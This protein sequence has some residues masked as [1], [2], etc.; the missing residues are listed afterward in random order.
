MTSTRMITEPARGAHARPRRPAWQAVGARLGWGYGERLFQAARFVTEMEYQHLV[1]EE[2]ARKVQPMVNVFGEGGTGYH[3]EINADIS[4]EFA[5]AVYRFGHSMLTE[6]STRIKGRRHRRQR[7][8]CSTPSSTRRPSWPGYATP[9]AAAGAVVRGMTR[10]V[11]QRDRRVRHRGAAQQ[12]AR[13]AARPGHASTWPGPAT[14]ASRRSTRRGA[15]FYAESGNTQL[16][17]Y[18]SWAD[19]GFSLKHPESLVNFIAAYGTHPSI[20]GA[21]LLAARR[22]AAA[23]L[24]YGEA[25]PDGSPRRRPDHRRRGRGEP[26]T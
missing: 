14:P 21:D 6:T 12:P 24:V 23:R 9:D 7:T 16:Q 2:F 17:P 13:P 22:T 20:T 19:F 25:G 18:E 26:T 8:R 5:H 3:T 15:P 1:F 11:R 4:A 10:Q